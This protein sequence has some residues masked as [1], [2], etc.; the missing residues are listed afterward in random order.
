MKNAVVKAVVTTGMY[1]PRPEPK[2]RLAEHQAKN[3]TFKPWKPCQMV[4][5]HSYV[6]K[7]G[8]VVIVSHEKVNDKE[9]HQAL[10]EAYSQLQK[11]NQFVKILLNAK[12]EIA[13]IGE[14]CILSELINI[15]NE[16]DKGG[17]YLD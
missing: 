10:F 15:G 7:N 2:N 14:P 11:D 16:L 6:S 3:G 8:N 5:R 9:L 13:K 12:G 4:Q 1:K 17:L